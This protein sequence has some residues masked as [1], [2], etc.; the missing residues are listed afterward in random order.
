MPDGGQLILIRYLILLDYVGRVQTWTM[1]VDGEL[2]QCVIDVTEKFTKLVN[3][4]CSQV[5]QIC[6]TIYCCDHTRQTSISYYLLT[7]HLIRHTWEN[8]DY[9]LHMNPLSPIPPTFYKRNLAD[10]WEK[11][12][13][14]LSLFLDFKEK[15]R[16]EI[17]NNIR[18]QPEIKCLIRDYI[19]NLLNTKPT[20]ILDHTVQ[21]FLNLASN[22]FK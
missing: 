11:D 5:K 22:D 18:D 4:H 20:D 1:N 10:C 6:R 9:Y 3:G 13:E 17:K 12:M 7:G 19:L 8:C 15:R 14:L 16:E 21:Y 2:C